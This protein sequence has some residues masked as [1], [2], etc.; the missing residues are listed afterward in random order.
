[1]AIFETFGIKYA[2]TDA[3][4]VGNQFFQKQ[5]LYQQW[6]KCQ[7]PFYNRFI[8]FYFAVFDPFSNIFIVGIVAWWLQWELPIKVCLIDRSIIIQPK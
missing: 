8:V 7:W 5:S 3:T 4:R 1:M 6:S 2:M